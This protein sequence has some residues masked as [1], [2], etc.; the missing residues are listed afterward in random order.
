LHRASLRTIRS[1]RSEN[2]FGAPVRG[3]E[4]PVGRNGALR[5]VAL[6]V[7]SGVERT[8][9]IFRIGVPEAHAPMTKPRWNGDNS[10]FLLRFPQISDSTCRPLGVIVVVKWTRCVL[11]FGRTREIK[12][13]RTDFCNGTV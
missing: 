4:V 8:L 5:I 3:A 13:V 2:A 10:V 11:A 12:R 9:A 1:S 7:D 6:K